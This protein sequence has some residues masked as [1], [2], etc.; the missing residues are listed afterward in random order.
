MNNAEAIKRIEHVGSNYAKIMSCMPTNYTNGYMQAV[1]DCK[2]QFLADDHIREGTK[3]AT[4]DEW[5]WSD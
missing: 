1:R 5:W 4:G 2:L 3:K